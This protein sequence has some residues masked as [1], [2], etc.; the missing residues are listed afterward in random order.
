MEI[1]QLHSSQLIDAPLDKVWDFFTYAGN[2]KLLTPPYMDMR[3]T[4][5]DLPATIHAGQLISYK[6]K[7]VAGIPVSWLTEITE[8]VPSKLFVDEQRKGPYKLWHHEHR[9]E[10]KDGKVLMHDTVHYQLP[11]SILGSLAHFLFVKRQLGNI[12][13]YRR[14]QIETIFG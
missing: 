12:F 7:P 9:F 3:I 8:V 2:L 6:L 4:S 1:H 13:N 14:K 11:F 10:E 5:G